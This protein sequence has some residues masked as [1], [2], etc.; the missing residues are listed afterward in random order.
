M[1]GLTSLFN[2]TLNRRLT[3]T[4]NPLLPALKSLAQT[5]PFVYIYVYEFFFFFLYVLCLH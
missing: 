2:G 4:F 1:G 5:Q 3:H